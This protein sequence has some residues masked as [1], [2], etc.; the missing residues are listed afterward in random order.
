MTGTD[1]SLC[2]K[3]WMGKDASSGRVPHRKQG[4]SHASSSGGSWKDFLWTSRKRSGQ[5]ERKKISDIC[6]KQRTWKIFSHFLWSRKSGYPLPAAVPVSVC[7]RYRQAMLCRDQKVNISW[8]IPV[9]GRMICCLGTGC[10]HFCPRQND[11]AWKQPV[12]RSAFLF[13]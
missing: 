2:T 9:P 6:A 5:P 12:C 3:D 10:P 7:W 1:G 13:L 8:E 11:G 4:W